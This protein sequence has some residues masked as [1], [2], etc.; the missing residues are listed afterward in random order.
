VFA[1][2]LDL[3]NLQAERAWLNAVLDPTSSPTGDESYRLRQCWFFY[4]SDP[5][6][7]GEFAGSLDSKR[8]VKAKRLCTP[9]FIAHT[10]SN[11]EYTQ[12]LYTRQLNGYVYIDMA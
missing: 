1:R 7:T 4:N 9:I 11:S 10:G 3:R 2:I 8:L 6:I 5:V 12:A